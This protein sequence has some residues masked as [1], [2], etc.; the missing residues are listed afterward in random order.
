MNIITK[1][2]SYFFNQIAHLYFRKKIIFGSNTLFYYPFFAIAKRGRIIIGNNCKLNCYLVVDGDGLIKI[3]NNCS[4]GKNTSIRSSKSIEMGNHV[5]IS[6]EV[7]V[8]DNNSHSLDYLERRKDIDFSRYGY[9][10]AQSKSILIG[11]DV[12]VGRRALILKGVR[13][14]DRS[15][16]AAGSVVTK[17]VPEDCVMAGN[18]AI[19]VKHL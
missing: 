6:A 9:K 8:L 16:I 15:I 12:W 7:I 18:P 13:I 19:I 14:G 10:T 11:N 17:D 3:G 1:T 2:V 5:L 4:I